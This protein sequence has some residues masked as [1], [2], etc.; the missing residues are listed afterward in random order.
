M[1]FQAPD[2]T[3][4][5][6]DVGRG[7]RCNIERKQENFDV[8]TCLMPLPVVADSYLKGEYR[9]GPRDRKKITQ[10]GFVA[11]GDVNDNYW[12]PMGIVNFQGALNGISVSLASA[13]AGLVAYSLF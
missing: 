1:T 9:W 13:V 2:L 6:Y 7:F 5:D 10:F 4:A 12:V 11:D 3:L 8:A